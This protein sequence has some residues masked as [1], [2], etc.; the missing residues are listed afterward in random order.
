[1][2][3]CVG[4]DRALFSKGVGECWP[5]MLA[6]QFV[7]AGIKN[8]GKATLER[9][10]GCEA[11]PGARYGDLAVRRTGRRKFPRSQDIAPA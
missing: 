5:L 10:Q 9:L 11:L 4:D 2:P 3:L 7:A 8:V 1:M 6:F